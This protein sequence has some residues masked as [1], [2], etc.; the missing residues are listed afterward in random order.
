MSEDPGVG[1]EERDSDAKRQADES[2]ADTTPKPQPPV[3]PT[4]AT[5]SGQSVIESGERNSS[6]FHRF[7]AHLI[8]TLRREVRD[9]YGGLPAD[10]VLVRLDEHFPKHDFPGRMMKRLESEQSARLAHIARADATDL[11]VA[12]TDHENAK[13]D[14]IL[15]RSWGKRAERVLYVLVGA[16]LVLIFTGHETAGAIVLGTTVVGVVGAFLSQAIGD[17]N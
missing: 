14:R 13:E 2:G 16:A 7:E 4:E 5:M 1:A 6:E 15:R 17:K 3:G 10:D 9:P 8:Q 12:Q 11:Y